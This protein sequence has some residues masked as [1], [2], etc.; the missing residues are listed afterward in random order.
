MQLFLGLIFSLFVSMLLI[1]LLIR[2]AAP[3]KLFDVPDS[4]KGHKGLIPRVGGIAIAVGTLFSTAILLRPNAAIQGYFLAALVIVAFG[5]LDDRVNL[6]YRLKLGGQVLAAVIAAASGLHFD[7]L[8]FFGLDPAPSWISFIATV[9]F[10]VAVTNAFNLLDGLDGLAAGCAVITLSSIAVLA[11]SVDAA[12]VLVLSVTAVGGVLGFLR[13]NTHPAT[14][15]MGD[16]GSQFL[17]FTIGALVTLLMSHA[18]NPMSRAVSLLIVGI[19]LL[20]TLLVMLLRWRAGKPVFAPDRNHIHHK[21]LSVGLFHHEAVCVIYIAQT[22]LVTLAFALRFES[23]ALVTTVYLG[24]C[25]F[26]VV[27]FRLAQKYR[28]FANREKGR[29][30]E[31]TFVPLITAETRARLLKVIVSGL[32]WLIAAYLV[33]GA[34]VLTRVSLDIGLAAMTAAFALTF[35]S[36]LRPDWRE[37]TSRIALYL[38]ATISAYL[39]IT[40]SEAGWLADP[41]TIVILFMVAAA[42][43]AAI[44]L[45]PREQFD[46][47]TLDVLIALL[48]VAMLI[49]PITADAKIKIALALFC[50]FIVIYAGRGFAR[51]TAD[52]TIDCRKRSDRQPWPHRGRRADRCHVGSRLVLGGDLKLVDAP[53]G[54][55]PENGEPQRKYRN[56]RRNDAHRGLDRC[57]RT[58]RAASDHHAQNARG[59][60]PPPAFLHK[61]IGVFYIGRSIALLT[62]AP[63]RLIATAAVDRE[64]RMRRA[65]SRCN[66]SQ[67]STSCSALCAR[68]C[69]AFEN[70]WSGSCNLSEDTNRKYT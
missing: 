43:A 31:T 23:D 70:D 59:V 38:A 30:F 22:L 2:L 45:M 11:H 44:Y 50:A 24:T 3:L 13:Y 20:D 67:R 21:L 49:A 27:A 34:I 41:R 48:T 62:Q 58:R 40:T 35:A 55:Q 56:S 32:E 10:L 17:G 36:W 15:F 37:G 5:I 33:V 39:A 1:P 46:V 8:P 29:L 64:D 6:S 28:W 9:I 4:R 18:E 65:K 51:S 60:W 57:F 54:E 19:P 66:R 16:A 63:L 47:T 68:Y 61:G 53:P 26:F 7:V 14:V 25:V 12:F 52:S 69:V 42:V